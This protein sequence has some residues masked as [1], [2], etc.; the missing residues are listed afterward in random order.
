MA[1]PKSRGSKQRKHKR[2]THFKIEAP[3][4]A[5]CKTTGERHLM[6]R[7][8]YDATG[9][10]FYRGKLFIEAKVVEEVGEE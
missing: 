5:T 1:H 6:H 7:A 10:L 4:V 2:R 9:N 8:Y 3:Q